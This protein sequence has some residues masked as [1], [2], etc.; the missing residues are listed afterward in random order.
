[1]SLLA[2]YNPCR[3]QSG[4]LDAQIEDPVLKGWVH[5]SKWFMLNPWI[6]F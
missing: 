6:V 3:I 1:M 4:A 2:C 5:E